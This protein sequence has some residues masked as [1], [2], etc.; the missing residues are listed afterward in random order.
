MLEKSLISK[1]IYP[2]TELSHLTLSCLFYLMPIVTFQLQSL[3]QGRQT[4]I[5]K[6]INEVTSKVQ[7]LREIRN[8]DPSN[9]T[10]AKQLRKMQTNLRLIQNE[11]TVEEVIRERSIKVRNYFM[12]TYNCICSN[13]III[14]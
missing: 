1:I 3:Y 4:S 5:Q 9:E 8:K 13:Y 2:L 11:L 7:E 12:C 10:V 14:M 6:C